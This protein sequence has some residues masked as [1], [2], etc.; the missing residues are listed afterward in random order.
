MQLDYRTYL[1][2]ILGGWIGKSIG[3]TLGARFEGVK[4]WIE[5]DLDDVIPE[6]I[7]PNDD[8]DLQVNQFSILQRGQLLDNHLAYLVVL[9]RFLDK[10]KGE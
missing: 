7:P 10:S 2:K 3:G 6:E 1:D 9:A 5:L 8:L 4:A